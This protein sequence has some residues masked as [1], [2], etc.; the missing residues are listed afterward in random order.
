MAE[1]NRRRKVQEDYNTLHN[2]T[3][4]SVRRAPE[5]LMVERDELAEIEKALQGSHTDIGDLPR[6]PKAVKGLI[7]R[8]RH[9]M[10]GHAKALQFEQAAGVRDQI[11]A[12]EKYLLSL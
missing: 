10:F 5:A 2:I 11:T 1:T 3:P 7:E 4:M 6:E 9:E 12:L 8:L